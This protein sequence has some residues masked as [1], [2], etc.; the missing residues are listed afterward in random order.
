MTYVI[1]GPCTGV[2]D[3]ACAGE[4]PVDCIYEA[5]DALHPPRR[6]RRL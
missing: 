3:K 6:V 4:C 2:K 1:T 5:A